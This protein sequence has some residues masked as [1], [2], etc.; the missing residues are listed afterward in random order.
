MNKIINKPRQ[1]YYDIQI[2]NAV[3]EGN[4]TQRLQFQETRNH[5]IIKN[6]GD[7]SLSIVRF[8]I[9]TYS[10]PSWIPEIE[11][12]QGS[13]NKMVDTI[14]LEY[15]EHIVSQNL[16]WVPTNKHIPPPS[17]QVGDSMDYTNEY[18]W[19]NSF[20]HYTDLVNT[21]FNSA[22]NSLKSIASLPNLR[23]PYMIWNEQN[24]TAELLTQE[25]FYNS[26]KVNHVKIYFNRPLYS[27]FTSLPA[28]KDYN[29]GDQNYHIT[30][31]DDYSTKL[32]MLDVDNNGNDILYIKT[33]QEFSTISN[34]TPVSSIVFT[35]NTLPI[36]PSQLSDPVI[37]R[38]GMQNTSNIA[39]NFSSII[40][41]MATNDLVYKPN[42]IYV[43]SAEYRFI[44]MIGNND[45]STID[46]SVF[47]KDKRGNLNP[48]ILQS[49]ASCSIKLLFQLKHI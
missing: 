3:S 21:A 4:T 28:E 24:Q 8:Q 37:Y 13:I 42:L 45:I 49:G 34:W 9:D 14:T 11:T 35:S 29:K 18:Y 2:N 17:G 27:R 48:F 33:P 39:K 23:S 43:P 38:N 36:I 12:N 32:V 31:K 30:I 47:F 44:D 22:T 15:G 1:I 40:S 26:S 19:A 10:L 41:D 46:I 5:P 20:R 16:I 7:Y 25:E 6:S